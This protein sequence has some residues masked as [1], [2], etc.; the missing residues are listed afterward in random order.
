M[1]LD[2]QLNQE[3]GFRYPH[4]NASTQI[5]LL[6]RWRH[7]WKHILPFYPGGVIPDPKQLHFKLMVVDLKDLQQTSYRALS[8]T[9][10]SV[11][12]K[13][14]IFQ[15]NVNGQP[16]WVRKNLHDFLNLL[17]KWEDNDHD[18]EG[19]IGLIFVDAICINQL[20][21]ERQDQV[22]LMR[23]I[24]RRADGVISWLGIPPDEAT[25]AAVQA[26]SNGLKVRRDM[27]NQADWT[28]EQRA[29]FRFLSHNK[30]W[31]RVWILQEILLGAEVVVCCGES[32]FPLR[33]FA[34]RTQDPAQRIGGECVWGQTPAERVTTYRL[35]TVLRSSSRNDALSQGLAVLS[36]K[37]MISE[38][39]RHGSAATWETR[40]CQTQLPDSLPDIISRYGHLE[41][42]DPRDRLYG[43]LGLLAEKTR[44]DI[45][46]DYSRGVDFAFYQGL[47]AGLIEV[48]Q[49]IRAGLG[50]SG[51]TSETTKTS[52][53]RID[54][55]YGDIFRAFRE[56]IEADEA[57]KISRQLL[58][59]LHI[60]TWLSEVDS[61][62]LLKENGH[63]A[64]VMPWRDYQKLRDGR[65][66]PDTEKIGER[67]WL[68]RWHNWQERAVKKMQRRITA[69]M[70]G[71]GDGLT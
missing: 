53:E 67:G 35:R 18:F 23:E 56:F 50:L 14:D 15:I 64:D 44:R 60:N 51:G 12:S 21:E 31:T 57:A 45:C 52:W 43:F 6:C 3:S 33:L 34:S 2:Q 41:C 49:E 11:S 27:T 22:H 17:P 16:F 71:H 20:G 61:A 10:G 42:S 8:Y 55:F 58:D 7:Y 68:E 28:P 1:D 32:I 46:V 62:L 40:E 47:R 9:W 19:G 25:N 65:R 29:G 24:Y 38:L 48:V 70:R 13:E 69:K 26:L 66:D 59:E 63:R 54:R 30:Y 5:R 4:I 36:M 39:Q 37:E